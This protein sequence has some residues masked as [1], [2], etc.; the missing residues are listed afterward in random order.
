V[1]IYVY[2]WT[3]VLFLVGIQ[4]FNGLISWIR[5]WKADH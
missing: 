1:F 2:L 3:Y 4:Q 5:Q